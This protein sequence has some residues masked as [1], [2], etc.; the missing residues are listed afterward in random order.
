MLEPLVFWKSIMLE[1]SFVKQPRTTHLHM[2]GLISSVL[3]LYLPI[4]TER[5]EKNWRQNSNGAQLSYHIFKKRHL[6][7]S[8]RSMKRTWAP[9]LNDAAK[10]CFCRISLLNDDHHQYTC[11]EY[12]RTTDIIHVIIA[13]RVG[14]LSIH[15]LVGKWGY[16]QSNGINFF[17][18]LNLKLCSLWT[19]SSWVLKYNA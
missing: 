10:S 4:L 11:Q 7:S 5:Q 8:K 18:G 14:G 19:K 9:E 17:P 1:K 12:H 2:V 15:A 13:K 3:C 16:L 6:T